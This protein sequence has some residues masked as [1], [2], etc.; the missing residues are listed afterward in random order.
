MKALKA[1]YIECSMKRNQPPPEQ[2]IG[3]VLNQLARDEFR[4][5]IRVKHWR[6]DHA[7]QAER[8]RSRHRRGY[9]DTEIWLGRQSEHPSPKRNIEAA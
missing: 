2:R 6:G 7:G 3:I 8:R 1:K 4:L 9:V 5:E